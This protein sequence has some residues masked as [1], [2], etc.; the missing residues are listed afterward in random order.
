[1]K[2][3]P[4]L[5]LLATKH[6]YSDLIC[7]P[8][9]SQPHTCGPY[10]GRDVSIIKESASHRTVLRS[11]V[12][13]L[14][15]SS[16]C[17]CRLADG[18]E[19]SAFSKRCGMCASCET[20]RRQVNEVLDRRSGTTRLHVSAA[21]GSAEQVKALLA[22][23]DSIDMTIHFCSSDTDTG[24]NINARDNS[25]STPL[26]IAA[27]QGGLVCVDALLKAKAGEIVKFT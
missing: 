26:H 10:K 16:R 20:L 7:F 14:S 25:G 24:A 11:S 17:R 4:T 13:G 1:M 12:L 23:G 22:L 3:T 27:E 15:Q 18:I 6:A 19:H 5:S 21:S 9:G 8:H 2:E